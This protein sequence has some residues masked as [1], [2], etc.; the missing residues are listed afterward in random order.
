MKKLFAVITILFV[1]LVAVNGFAAWT[2]SYSVYSEYQDEHGTHF[3][4][5]VKSVSDGA[6]GTCAMTAA[7]IGQTL[8]DGIYDKLLYSIVAVPGT[9]G[10]APTAAL[11][12][13]IT[14][15]IGATKF[16]DTA[17]FT[18]NTTEEAYGN[19][20][21]G[22]YPHMYNAWTLVFTDIG[23]AVD[24]YVLYLDFMR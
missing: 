10:A 8:F 9:G 4:I 18:T 23:D 16:N 14:D 1:M 3:V 21:S 11:D 2:C 17:T 7:N 20:Y 15:A 6:T 24:E 5:A 12:L 22:A 13:S 19:S